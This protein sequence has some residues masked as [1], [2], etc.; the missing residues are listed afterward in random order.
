MGKK[1]DR[2]KQ[3]VPV[4]IVGKP[5]GKPRSLCRRDL[6]QVRAD[7]YEKDIEWFDQ[8]ARAWRRISPS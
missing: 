4:R 5:D 8:P 7:S 1:K 2:S 6:L 3:F